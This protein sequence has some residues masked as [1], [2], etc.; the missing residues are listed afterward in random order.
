VGFA[1]ANHISSNEYFREGALMHR[2]T[3]WKFWLR[4]ASAV[5]ALTT[6]GAQAQE[7]ADD[8]IIVTATKREAALQDVPVA[9]TPVTAELIQNA[10]IRDIQD[11]QSVAPSLMFNVSESHSSA[12]ARL[13]GIGTQGSNPGLESAVGV[14]I[15]G[16]FRPRNSVALSDLGELSQIEVLR[17]PQGTLFG[18][19]TSAGLINITYAGPDLNEFST[20][21]EAGYGNFNAYRASG[22]V[23]VP[24]VTDE[25]AV[26]VYAATGKRDGFMDLLTR[27]G[28]QIETNTQDFWTVRGQALWEPTANFDVRL[29]A[30]Y[31]ERDEACCGAKIYNP[32]PY[33]GAPFTFPATT[34]Q[35][36]AQFGAWGP[37]TTAEGLARL[38]GSSNGNIED[39]DDRYGFTNFAQNNIVRENGYSAE[40]NWGVGG[41]ALT[42]ITAYRNWDFHGGG[43]RDYTAADI[44]RTPLQFAGTDGNG[45][46]YRT[47]SLELRANGQWRDVDWLVGF[48]YADENI[49]RN[50]RVEFGTDFPTYA[51]ALLSV[52][53]SVG[54][55]IAGL[56]PAQHG[57]LANSFAPTVNA[58]SF[59]RY[60]QDGSTAA[61]FTHNIWSIDDRTDLTVGL[62]YTVD[63]K[64]L[65]GRFLTQYNGFAAVGALPGQ[66]VAAGVSAPVAGGIAS[67]ARGFLALPW[68]RTA[69]DPVG[70]NQ[71]REE[72]EWSGIVSVRRDITE[73]MSAYVSVSRGYKGG[74]F[75]LDRAF[76]FVGADGQTPLPGVAGRPNTRFP[77]EFVDSFEVGVK[78][79][80]GDLLLNT[81]MYWSEFRD[82]QLNTFDGVAFFV[83]S[84]P[85]VT[86]QGVEIDA[87]WNTPI[88]GLSY[89]GGL[90]SNET[91][92]GDFAG[93]GT[94]SAASQALSGRRLTN[95]PLWA[96]SHAFTYEKP[97]FNDSMVGLAHLDFRYESLQVTGSDL[98]PTKNRPDNIIV[99]GRLGIAT[100][101]ETVAFEVW[102]KNLTDETH[103]QIAFDQPLLSGSLGAFLNEPRTF[104]ATVRISY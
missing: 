17:G 61:L 85:E 74:G 41:V 34:A 97:M 46:H 91:E 62:R 53:P 44:W 4:A 89:Q 104:G 96:T 19:N 76:N 40:A 7:A 86:S 64:N 71:S 14:I 43:D 81:A 80:I 77:A 65:S 90:A 57:V 37:G 101:N 28:Q 25:L 42:S 49:R 9:V 5:V 75:N 63:E 99:N 45:S 84:L 51:I 92:Y 35:V 24:I 13:R 6:G 20:N 78:S 47:L 83:S 29:V 21:V 39:D 56:T 38:R 18:R 68:L 60:E 52:N 23:S 32:T 66:L 30:D 79:R 82:Y 102:G 10:G 27:T 100:A 70:Y 69:L 73:D 2:N 31:S 103:A 50:E 55:L 26:R 36:A 98:A 15:D 87:I 72:H 59:D 95:A 11:L 93:V 94:L 3:T 54:P 12:T 58:G 48:Y 8:E 22:S 88:D 33:N 67:G 1:L 16:V